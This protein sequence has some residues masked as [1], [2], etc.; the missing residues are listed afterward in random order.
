M[1]EYFDN[2]ETAQVDGYKFRKD[3]K[4]GYFLSSKKIGGSRKRLHVY[5]WEK[6]HGAVP[7]GYHVHHK[8]ENKND[9]ELGNLELL[10]SSKHAKLHGS[11]LSDE[12]RQRRRERVI[13]V[14]TPAAKKWHGTQ[15]GYEWHSKHAKETMSKRK[16]IRYICTYCG[17]EFES[18]HLY[19]KNDNRFCSN[20][21]KCTYRRKQG[22]DN[23]VKICEGCGKEYVAN[24]YQQTKY[25]ED[26]KNRKGYPR[27]R[28]QHGGRG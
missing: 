8:D 27:G 18:K 6:E 15:E 12:E 19:G 28:V 10:S 17:N 24:K 25:C 16:L 1:I 5:I 3:K 23:I 7:K 4:T 21:C 2:Y 14:V 22:F 26:C 9:N 11:E 20:N 13:N